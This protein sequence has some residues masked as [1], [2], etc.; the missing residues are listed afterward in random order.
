PIK[1]EGYPLF[2]MMTW[3]KLTG[4]APSQSGKDSLCHILWLKQNTPELY[5]KTYKFLDP[6]DYINLRL[7]GKFA[8]TYDSILLH[9]VLT[10]VIHRMSFIQTSCSKWP[11]SSVQNCLI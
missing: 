8:A 4:G 1:I 9:W 10:T 3:L 6:K 2:K 11:E 7:T 5:R